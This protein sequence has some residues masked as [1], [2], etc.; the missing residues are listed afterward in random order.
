MFA[1]Y[2]GVLITIKEQNKGN[3]KIKETVNIDRIIRAFGQDSIGNIYV[4]LTKTTAVM[5]G[6]GSISMIEFK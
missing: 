6:D 3:W 2:S 4:C 1:D 5:K